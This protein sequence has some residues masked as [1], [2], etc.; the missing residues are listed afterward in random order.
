MKA[1][2][3]L[4]ISERMDSNKKRDRNENGLIRMGSK[5]RDVLGLSGEKVV[6]VWPDTDA[7]DRINRSRS[8][9]IFQAYSSDLK[10]AKQSMSEDDFLLVGFVTTNTFNYVCKDGRKKKQNIWLAD[11]IEDTI[12]GGDPEFILMN[13]DGTIQYAAEISGFSY[14]AA[15]GSDGPLA[16]LRPDPAISVDDFVDNMH[17]ILCEHPNTKIIDPYRWVGGCFF[18]EKRAGNEIASSWP[19]GGHIH[20]GTPVQLA[21]KIPS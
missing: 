10:K 13:D 4:V 7:K 6:E 5:A 8:L 19:A 15:L 14:D 18:N 12:I 20:I 16:E 3:I 1:P 17:T 9:E 11:S 21:H 2:L